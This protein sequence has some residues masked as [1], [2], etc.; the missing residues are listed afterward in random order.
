MGFGDL[1]R[2]NVVLEENV[3]FFMVKTVLIVHALDPEI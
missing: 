2:D 1:V 3:T